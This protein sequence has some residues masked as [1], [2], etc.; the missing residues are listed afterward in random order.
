MKR[1]QG[2]DRSPSAIALEEVIKERLPE[3][4]FL[5]ILAR[6]AYWLGWW[7]RFGPASGSDPKLA[8]PALRYV[9]LN[10]FGYGRNLGPAQAARH[11]RG[12]SAHELG[13]TANRHFSIDKLNRA[14]A[15]VINAYLRL[16]LAKVWGD[17]SWAE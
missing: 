16:D 1:R 7:R 15:D 17:A 6:T 13:A 5:D 3:R 8:D 12:V 4:P 2:K 11:M 10:T 14:I 9:I